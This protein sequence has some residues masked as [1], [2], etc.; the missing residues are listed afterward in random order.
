MLHNLIPRGGWTPIFPSQSAF[1]SNPVGQRLVLSGQQPGYEDDL[2][3]CIQERR[4]DTDI[5]EL[6]NKFYLAN[7]TLVQREP[8]SM[9]RPFIIIR[10][11]EGVH[12]GGQSTETSRTEARTITHTPSSFPSVQTWLQHTG[13]ITDEAWMML[14][15]RHVGFL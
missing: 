6:F 2:L 5:E 11:A 10:G 7:S 3:Y 9:E 14:P 12:H 8:F 1:G 13:S 15:L 4:T